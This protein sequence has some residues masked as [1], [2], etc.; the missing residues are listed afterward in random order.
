MIGVVHLAAQKYCIKH[1]F[2]DSLVKCGIDQDDYPAQKRFVDSLCWAAKANNIHIHL[3]HHIRKGDTEKNKPGKFDVKGAGEITDLVDNVFI[4]YR[5]K[6]KEERVRNNEDV[7]DDIPDALV[8]CE[9]Q[10]HGEWE[11]NILLWVHKKSMQFLP[12]YSA[13]PMLYDMGCI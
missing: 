10:R 11:G 7:G 9:K 13:S 2:I 3:I 12:K 4:V 6:R 5:N 8:I 1:E